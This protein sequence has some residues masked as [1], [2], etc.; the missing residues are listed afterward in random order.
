M[1]QLVVGDLP[2]PSGKCPMIAHNHGHFD[3]FWANR[4]S[5]E[6]LQMSFVYLNDRLPQWSH[7][8]CVVHLVVA[9]LVG[10]SVGLSVLVLKDFSSRLIEMV[11]NL[12]CQYVLL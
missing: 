9:V 10:Q 7:D 12:V 1:A 8:S 11:E 6:W 5:V 4:I 2:L 3:T